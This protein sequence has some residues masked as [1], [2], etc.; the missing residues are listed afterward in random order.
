MRWAAA[1]YPARHRLLVVWNHGAGFM[2]E[3]TR[4]IGYDDSSKGDALTMA[5]LR[6]ALEKAGFGKSPQGRLALLGFDACLM[7]MV[8]V[9][10]EFIGLADFVVGSQ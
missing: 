9:A 1:R 10:Y 3:P 2:H 5:E 8:E 6:W 7:N 4:D